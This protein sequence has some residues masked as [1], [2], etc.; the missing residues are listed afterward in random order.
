MRGRHLARDQSTN[1]Q[2][3]RGTT[4]IIQKSHFEFRYE[5]RR[6]KKPY[7][8]H[9]TLHTY[10]EDTPR[11]EKRAFLGGGTVS[12]ELAVAVTVAVA[13]TEPSGTCETPGR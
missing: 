4:P 9:V 7:E 10:P 3:T 12:L 11:K 1:D 5:D 6:S 8:E 13:A 2:G